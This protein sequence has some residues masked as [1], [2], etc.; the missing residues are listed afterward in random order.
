MLMKNSLW[1]PLFLACAVFA[2]GADKMLLRDL[3]PSQRAAVFQDAS[4]SCVFVSQNDGSTVMVRHV[5]T[6][7]CQP[8]A[9][10]GSRVCAIG[11]EQIRT[12]PV[13]EEPYKKYVADGGVVPASLTF[14]TERPCEACEG[15]GKFVTKNEKEA[16]VPLHVSG[17][18]KLMGGK[19][20]THKGMDNVSFCKEC[21]GKGKVTVQET[22]IVEVSLK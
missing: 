9:E 8:A 19:V 18:G 1:I 13:T 20:V 17:T 6:E 10:D 21:N 3:T 12:L 15:K 4:R 2:Q 16:Y 11:E 22:R 7:S 14:E 5:H